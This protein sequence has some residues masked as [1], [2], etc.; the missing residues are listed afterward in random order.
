MSLAAFCILETAGGHGRGG[1]TVCISSRRSRQRPPLAAAQRIGILSSPGTP[2]AASRPLLLAPESCPPSPKQRV[3][4]SPCGPVTAALGSWLNTAR[5][6]TPPQARAAPETCSS[7]VAGLKQCRSQAMNQVLSDSR[8][9]TGTNDHSWL[10]IWRLPLPHRWRPPLPRRP[11]HRPP[12]CRS[13]A[14]RASRPQPR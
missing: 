12:P 10:A 7:G 6:N 13:C 14:P 4:S 3:S 9:N 11:R 2:P 8:T 5:D 1:A